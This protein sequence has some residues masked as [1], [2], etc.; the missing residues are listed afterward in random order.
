MNTW[1]LQ[2]NY[3]NALNHDNSLQRKH[4]LTFKEGIPPSGVDAS[5][6]TKFTTFRI[7]GG[8]MDNRPLIIPADGVAL[9]LRTLYN[10]NSYK[11]NPL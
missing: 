4:A 6:S 2:K 3:D 5:V 10:P 7:F 11:P 8:R 9:N 1:I